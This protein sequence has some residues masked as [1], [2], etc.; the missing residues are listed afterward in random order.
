MPR[1]LP[2]NNGLPPGT[3]RLPR[4]MSHPP[5]LLREP[6]PAKPTVKAGSGLLAAD[7]TPMAKV[8]NPLQVMAVQMAADIHAMPDFTKVYEGMQEW[9]QKQGPDFQ[10]APQQQIT[11]DAVK[12]MADTQQRCRT[13]ILDELA[14]QKREKENKG[15]AP[16]E[17]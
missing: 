16:K 15:S 9:V 12:I 13:L 8:E 11:W 10:M 7:G 14:R 5:R 1:P 4:H 3:P 6:R 2:F 17:G